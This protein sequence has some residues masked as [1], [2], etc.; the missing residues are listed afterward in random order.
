MTGC[1]STDICLIQYYNTRVLYNRT[2]VWQIFLIGT[3]VHACMPPVLD[4]LLEYKRNWIQ[5]VNRMPRNRLPRVMKHYS[6][7]GKRNH[8]RPLKRLLDTWD[9]NGSTSGPT[10]WQIYDDDK[11]TNDQWI[12]KAVEGS[13]HGLTGHI[14]VVLFCREWGMPQQCPVRIANLWTFL[15][16]HSLCSS[17][18]VF[19]SAHFYLK[20]PHIV[21][22]AT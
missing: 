18:N 11:M 3:F 4:K 16:W 17:C 22:I 5:N 21:S 12:E 9:Q 8:G 6:P 2:V 20:L 19:L 14:T 7:T 10:P 13:G 1:D 15:P